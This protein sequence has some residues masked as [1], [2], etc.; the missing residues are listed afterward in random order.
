[1]IF[2]AFS[3]L[4]RVPLVA[5]FGRDA[6]LKM[7]A[8][9]AHGAT[10]AALRLGLAPEQNYADPQE[11]KVSLCGLDFSNPIG[12]AAGFDK[13]G[14]V[15]R[16]L[17]RVGF[18]MVE[19][20]TV[21]PRPQGGNPKPRLFRVPEVDGVINRMGFNNEGHEAMFERLKTTRVGA[22]LG[23]NIGA[24]KDSEDFV[25]DYVLGVNRF[26]ALADYL[27]VNISSP[28]TPGLRNLQAE[29]A[30]ARLLDAVLQARSK[31][32]VRV[33]VFLKIA[34]DLDEKAMDGIARTILATDLDGLIVSNTTIGR[35]AVAGMTN[36]TEAGGLSGKP[37]FNLATRRLAQMRQR[38]GALPIIGV[39][40]IH[41]PE[42]A[43]AKFE[44]GANAIQLYSALVY[45]GFDMLDRLK[46]GLAAGVRS[47]GHTS[48]S[49]LT[50][51]TTDDWAA[52]K[53]S[54]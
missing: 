30:L 42:T 33:P 20:G 48:I 35:D 36:A 5:N 10:I 8:E 27:T 46:R 1:M 16:Q 14:E 44:A 11:L 13:N 22:I 38:V 18:G 12:M 19:V 6:L 31:A 21:T 45:G 32:A 9:T 25:A 54:L 24:N 53:L 23:V 43:L 50:G 41:S 29:E 52:G 49:A 28:N 34:P 47:A 17:A 39:G 3:P 51:R 15:P 2:S 7:D 37:L 4:L 26:A 40:G